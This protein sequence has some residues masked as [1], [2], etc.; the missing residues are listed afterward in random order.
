[1]R[2][3]LLDTNAYS[4]FKSG[5]QEVLSIIQHTDI[6]Y[7]NPIIL[8]ELMAGFAH[9]KFY[10]KNMLELKQFLDNSRVQ[11]CYIDEVTPTYYATIYA[12]LKKKGKPIPTN[13]L[14]IAA[15]ALQYGCKLCSFD[16][17][18]SLIDNLV[19]AISLANFL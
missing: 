13:D 12:S 5:N 14:W 18:F 17:H 3:L 2:K 9:G 19:V 8:G 7:I 15:S 1:M 10:E 16:Q 11:V 4:A 6:L